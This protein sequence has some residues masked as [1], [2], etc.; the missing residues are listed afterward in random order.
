VGC[1]LAAFPA[2]IVGSWVGG[3]IGYDASD[4]TAV[5]AAGTAGLLALALGIAAAIRESRVA[6]L[7]AVLVALSVIGLTIW[8]VNELIT[9]AS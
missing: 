3:H 8:V 4:E 6:G 1:A 2:F 7:G 5:I 9:I